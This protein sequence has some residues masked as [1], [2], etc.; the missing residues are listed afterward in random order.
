MQFSSRL[1]LVQCRQKFAAMDLHIRKN[2]KEVFEKK[3]GQW[4]IEDITVP[5]F[6]RQVGLKRKFSA[7]DCH[8]ATLAILE[9]PL[10]E[11]NWSQKFKGA[12]DC[13]PS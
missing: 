3:S 8:L 9:S 1:P 6:T 11:W 5:S 4:K 13:L 10:V 7:V 12:L 2:L